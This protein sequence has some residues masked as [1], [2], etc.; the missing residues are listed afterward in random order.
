V[1]KALFTEIYERKNAAVADLV[2]LLWNQSNRDLY[3]AMHDLV[4]EINE[5]VEE[6]EHIEDDRAHEMI[7]T[8][9][10]TF[11]RDDIY[12]CVR[13]NEVKFSEDVI[14]YRLV[15]GHD[16]WEPQDT[17]DKEA[18]TEAEP[19]ERG[20]EQPDT[21]GDSANVSATKDASDQIKKDAEVGISDNFEE[22][23]KNS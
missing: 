1:T 11:S 5:N 16:D 6:I 19:G 12:L 22:E 21:T 9:L 20:D 8:L 18:E 7:D 14:Q 15:Q 2:N 17:Q 4:R 23:Q 13:M 3:K 10:K